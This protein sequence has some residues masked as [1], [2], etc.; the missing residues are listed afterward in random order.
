MVIAVYHCPT[1]TCVYYSVTIETPEGIELSLENFK[2]FEPIYLK[3]LWRSIIL[4][5]ISTVICLILGYPAALI[6]A[7]KSFKRS[8]TF[9]YAFYVTDVDEFPFANLC[10]G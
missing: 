3:V 8:N 2:S 5:L 1:I 10:S 7:G 6:L 9:N 4:A